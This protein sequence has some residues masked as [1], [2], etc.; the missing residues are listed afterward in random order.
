MRG[1]QLLCPTAISCNGLGGCSGRRPR[2]KSSRDKTITRRMFCLTA[3]PDGNLKNSRP[4][5]E[6]AAL[7]KS[8]PKKTSQANPTPTQPQPNP[9]PIPSPSRALGVRQQPGSSSPP[10]VLPFQLQTPRRQHR[11][12]GQQ[13]HRGDLRNAT[14][15]AVRGDLATASPR[16]VCH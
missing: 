8:L 5:S 16:D 9:S 7:T 14:V 13:L 2:Q 1:L 6:I 11:D 4:E 15:P 10:A 12:E 3:E